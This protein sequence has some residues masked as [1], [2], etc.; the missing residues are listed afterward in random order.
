ME[1]KNM[2]ALVSCFARAYHYKD[3]TCRIFCDSIAEKILRE[4]EYQAIA[5]QMTN[6]IQ[7]FCPDFVGTKEEALRR[8]VDHQLSPSVLGRSAF[9]EKA[10]A[11]A[12]KEGCKQYLIF[13]A[14]Y[15]TFAYRNEEDSLKVFEIDRKEMIADKQKRLNERCIDDSGVEF[16]SCD[17]TQENWYNAVIHSN[18]RQ[19]QISFS[20][21]LGISYY[22]TKEE[23]RNMIKAIANMVCEGSRIAFD[24]PT[25][26]EGKESKVNRELASAAKESMKDKYTKNEM[27][28]VLASQGFAVV[29][30]L[31]D[32]EM[33]A[34]YFADYNAQTSD[35]MK[36]PV[37]VHYCLAV[38]KKRY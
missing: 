14:G 22:L 3:N 34:Q 32:K 30:D 16:I 17:F 5:F 25:E 26:E 8:I 11:K 33:T 9:C 24:Y 1:E 27:E 37:G 13:A 28:E 7:F 4:E 29:E 18:Y 2:T 35:K 12:V 10:L 31:D 15:D 23:F 38:K 19:D 6:G 20:S 36:A 21:L